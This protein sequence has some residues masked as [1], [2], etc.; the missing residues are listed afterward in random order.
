MHRAIGTKAET[1]ESVRLGDERNVVDRLASRTV[2]PVEQEAN[3]VAGHIDSGYRLV[4]QDKG[5][6][7]GDGIAHGRLAAELAAQ[8]HGEVVGAG[9]DERRGLELQQ[10]PFAVCVLDRG[11]IAPGEQ[12]LLGDRGKLA[13]GQAHAQRLVHPRLNRTGFDRL[14]YAVARLGEAQAI[15]AVS[16]RKRDHVAWLEREAG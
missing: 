14:I 11:E 13:L 12:R 8:Q 1:A 5:G 9:R 10:L 16:G 2:A 15:V 7:G 4:E 6:A 3:I